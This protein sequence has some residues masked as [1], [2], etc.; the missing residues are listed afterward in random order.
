MNSGGLGEA[1]L[2][3]QGAFAES[4]GAKTKVAESSY[5]A[6]QEEFAAQII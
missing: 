6:Q 3:G 5:A 4:A 2:R 1:A